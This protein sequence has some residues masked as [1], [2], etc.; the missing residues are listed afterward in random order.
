VLFAVCQAV[1]TDPASGSAGYQMAV[2][3]YVAYLFRYVDFADT[4]FFHLRKKTGHV[5]MLQITHHFLMPMYGWMLMCWVP[6]GQSTFGM[7]IN[8][9]V[10]SIMYSY[11][12]VAALG[13][14][15]QKYLWWK[16]YLTNLQIVQFVVVLVKEVGIFAGYSTC[17]YPWQVSFVSI[18]LTMLFLTL[19]GNFYWQEYISKKNKKNKSN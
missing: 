16:R 8:A 12:F 19:F 5:S 18:V 3:L 9:I 4:I 1:D 10:H 13:P 14:Q 6:G 17:D 2:T 11:Y 15:Y 7:F